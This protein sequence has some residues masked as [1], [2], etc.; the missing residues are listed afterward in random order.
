MSWRDEEYVGQNDRNDTT[1]KE[2]ERQIYM[3]SYECRVMEDRG[4]GWFVLEQ[5]HPVATVAK[6]M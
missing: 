6:E 3:E 2:E 4:L 1:R 5:K